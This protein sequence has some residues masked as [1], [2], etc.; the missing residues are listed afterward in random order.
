LSV[1]DTGDAASVV[2]IAGGFPHLL[3]AKQFFGAAELE[4]G[5]LLQGQKAFQEFA[6]A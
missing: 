6:A 2:G 5:F 3:N 1:G 4:M